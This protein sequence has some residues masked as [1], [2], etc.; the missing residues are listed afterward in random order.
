MEHL[1][2][3]RTKCLKSSRELHQTRTRNWLKSWC[4]CFHWHHF[5][6]TDPSNRTSSVPSACLSNPYGPQKWGLKILNSSLT[7]SEFA[8]ESPLMAR[9]GFNQT[10]SHLGLGS[11]DT[12]SQLWTDSSVEDFR[13]PC[14]DGSRLVLDGDRD[15]RLLLPGDGTEPRRHPSRTSALPASLKP[16]SDG[17][18][19]IGGIMV[20]PV[21]GTRLGVTSP[22]H[23]DP[24]N[25]VNVPKLIVGSDSEQESAVA[26]AEPELVPSNGVSLLSQL[27]PFGDKVFWSGRPS[28][29]MLFRNRRAACLR[30]EFSRFFRL[31]SLVPSGTVRTELLGPQAAAAAAMVC[32]PLRKSNPGISFRLSNPLARSPLWAHIGQKPSTWWRR[33]PEHVVNIFKH[34]VNSTTMSS[35]RPFSHVRSFLSK[36][37]SGDSYIESYYGNKS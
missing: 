28:R 3:N 33:K 20:S 10:N 16:G 34:V 35:W 9:F 36:V 22:P 21:L 25:P 8:L 12:E 4:E 2:L 29:E 23:C 26:A 24:E 11:D 1:Q 32:V 37:T 15:S 31:C 17:R 5:I 7:S 30:R 18:T 13:G 27:L 14:G 19:R 6:M